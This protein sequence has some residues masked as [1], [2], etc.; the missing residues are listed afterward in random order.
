MEHQPTSEL[1]KRG[2]ISLAILGLFFGFGWLVWH[3]YSERPQL[4]ADGQP[5]LVRV[6]VKNFKTKPE[7]PEGRDY[8]D[9]RS[10]FRDRLLSKV[11][12]P[13]T[14]PFKR[15]EVGLPPEGFENAA[16]NPLRDLLP[17]LKP[18]S[19][20]PG[21]DVEEAES[22][23]VPIRKPLSTEPATVASVPDA[24]LPNT[25]SAG[26]SA[27]EPVE[28]T[29]PGTEPVYRVQILASADENAARS[30]LRQLQ[31]RYDDLIGTMPPLLIRGTDGM[32]R[33]RI[34]AFIE[35]GG[36]LSVCNALKERG[37]DCFV[38]ND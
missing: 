19:V 5:R 36:A 8:N 18:D 22:W 21:D 1:S 13:V 7:D 2:V 4:G 25:A 9:D 30:G 14:G 10:P 11:N 33:A 20:S 28:I 35:S 29:T 3:S 38:T 12:E 34:G 24:S 32:Y 16:N 37:Q 31:S 27:T 17:Q 23:P 26:S 15:S 6:D